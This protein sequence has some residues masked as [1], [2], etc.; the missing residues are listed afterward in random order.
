[1]LVANPLSLPCKATG[2]PTPQITWYRIIEGRLK[3]V[4]LDHRITQLDN[5][6]LVNFAS[7]ASDA[8]EYICQASSAGS[9]PARQRVMVSVKGAERMINI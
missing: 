6:T 3:I 5:G 4:E 8:G 2:F 1:M 7:E 9:E